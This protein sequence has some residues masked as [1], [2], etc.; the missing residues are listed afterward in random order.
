[1]PTRRRR[2]TKRRI[3][4]HRANPMMLPWSGERLKVKRTGIA[5]TGRGYDRSALPLTELQR[6]V[7]NAV[8]RAGGARVADVVER[9]GVSKS[10]ATG[11][12]IALWD[13][14]LLEK[15]GRGLYRRA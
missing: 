8:P 4:Q 7:L 3:A 14:G 5:R 13:R 6:H 9:V 1:M 12:L 2:T 11:A 10:S 15:P